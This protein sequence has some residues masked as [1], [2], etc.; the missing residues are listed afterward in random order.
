MRTK[1]EIMEEIT[2]AAASS[3]TTTR[4]DTFAVLVVELLADIR[5]LLLSPPRGK[6]K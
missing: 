5:D 2:D 3:F 6:E 1:K 4:D